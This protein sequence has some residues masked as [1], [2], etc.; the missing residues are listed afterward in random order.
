[1]KGLLITLALLMP[2]S[3]AM[4][5]QI[6]DINGCREASG[7]EEFWNEWYLNHYGRSYDSG[8]RRDAYDHGSRA[9]T[10]SAYESSRRVLAQST[11]DNRMAAK[12][13]ALKACVNRS[14]HP[15]TCRVT[16]N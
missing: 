15:G 4:A 6:C 8:Y 16:C 7:S 12:R 13:R 11:S 3:S 1:M 9:I 10:C 2:F 14:A 5:S